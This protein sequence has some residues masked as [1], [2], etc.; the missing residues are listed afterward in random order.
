MQ[1][2]EKFGVGAWREIRA[3]LLPDVRSRHLACA[4]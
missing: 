1:G 2:L 4:L 3:Q